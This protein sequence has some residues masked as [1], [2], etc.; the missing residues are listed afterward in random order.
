MSLVVSI[1]LAAGS[2][3]RMKTS[4]KKQY[5]PLGGRPIL[6]RT[7]QVFEH[8]EIIDQVVLVVNA[9]DVDIVKRQIVQPFGC[10]KVKSI[11]AGGRER[12]DSVYRGLQALPANSR[13]VVVHD[14]A[15]P[16]LTLDVLENVVKAGMEYQAAVAAVP[17]KDTI[18]MA[19]CRGFVTETPDRTRLWTVQTPQVFTK[20]LIVSSYQKAMEDNFRGTDDASLVERMGYPVKLVEGSYENIK[21]TTP[22][23]LLLAEALL[24]ER[25]EEL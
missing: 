13:M 14:G 9:E 16:L 20:E 6:A 3:T 22:E 19:D 15:R 7:L 25:E 8:S 17:V 21:I 18:K 12:Q 11:V 23:D 4:Q 10:K 24:K 2:G 1:V 5:L